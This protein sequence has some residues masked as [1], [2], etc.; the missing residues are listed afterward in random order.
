MDMITPVHPKRLS[1]AFV[2]TITTPGR[3]GDGRG[4]FGLSLLVK[5]TRSG[6]VSRSW[7]QRL[8]I[9]GVAFNIGIGSFPG[10]TLSEARKRAL[11][12][13]R[14][15]ETGGDPR[16]KPQTTPTFKEAMERTIEVLRPGWKQ[17]ERLNIKCGFS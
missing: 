16:R 10:V 17:G 11:A 1:A 7:S 12:N 5:P 8:R 15:V 3:Y 2:Q 6:R 4:G 14:I 9:D 13:L